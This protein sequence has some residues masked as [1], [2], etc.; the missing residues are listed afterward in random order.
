MKII[1]SVKIIL[2]VGQNH[3]FGGRAANPNM[4]NRS[5]GIEIYFALLK[6]GEKVLTPVLPYGNPYY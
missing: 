6:T 1:L 5:N 4:P 2:L 3:T